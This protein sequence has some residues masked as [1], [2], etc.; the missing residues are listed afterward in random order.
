MTD[1]N[2]PQRINIPVEEMAMIDYTNK[3]KL[4]NAEKALKTFQQKITFLESE[5]AK[6]KTVKSDIPKVK[7]D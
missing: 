1:S 3:L 2:Q 6:Y 7:K 4:A 5:L